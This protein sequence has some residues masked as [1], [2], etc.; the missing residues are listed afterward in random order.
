MRK[1]LSAIIVTIYLFSNVFTITTALNT[2]ERSNPWT[3]DKAT[4]LARITLFNADKNT[5]D[6]LVA[7]GSAS[8]AVNLL[9]P[10]AVGPD[11]VSFNTTITNY[12]ASGFNWWDANHTTRL[13]QLMYAWDPYE[14][15]RKLFSLFEDIFSVNRDTERDITYRDVYDLHSLLF[16]NM[17]GN[18]QVLVKKVLNNNGSPGDYAAGR[19]LDLFNQKD[20]SKPNENFARELLQLFL[21]G[22][23]EPYRSKDDGDIRNYEESDVI[24]LAKILTG[25]KSDSMTHVVSF[26]M[27]NHYSV[28]PLKF[29]SDSIVWTPPPYYNVASG[30][31]DPV[32]IINSVNGN[33]WLTD[34]VIEYI[35]AQKSDQIA[36]FLADR[37]ARFYMSDKPSRTELDQIAQVIKD[38]NF[39]MLPSIKTIL[40]L[41]MIY[42]NTSMNTVRY[43]NP[44]ELTIGSIRFF[45]NNTLSGITIDPNVYDTNLL[46]RLGWTPYFPGSIFGRDGFDN[47]IKWSSTSTQGAWMSASNYFT[48]RNSG[49]GALDFLTMLG[50]QKSEITTGSISVMTHTD[51]SYSGSLTIVS[52]TLNLGDSTPIVSVARMSMA[53]V[54]SFAFD[55]IETPYVYPLDP[56]VSILG[57]ENLDL[58]PDIFEDWMNSDGLFLPENEI[59]NIDS[60]ESIETI[61]PPN[62]ELIV[63]STGTEEKIIDSVLIDTGS[64]VLSEFLIDITGSVLSSESNTTN[65]GVDITGSIVPIVEWVQIIKST[66]DTPTDFTWTTSTWDTNSWI[67][68]ISEPITATWVL[69]GSSDSWVILPVVWVDSGSTDT[70][71]LT[72]K[73]TQSVSTQ[74]VQALAVPLST[75]SISTGTVTLPTFR[76]VTGLGTITIFS[77]TYIWDTR[78]LMIHSGFVISSTSETEILPG[79]S[80]TFDMNSRLIADTIQA[81]QIIDTYEN[82]IYWERRLQS[83]VRL[84]LRNFLTHNSS[85]ATIP[86]APTNTMYFNK[87]IRGLLSILMSQPEY[88]LLSGYDLPTIT[89][90]TDQHF[91][92]GITGKLFF[93]ELYGGNDYMTS[94][95]PKDEYSTYLDYRSNQSGSIAITGT[96]LVDIGDFYMNSALA[97][98]SGGWPGFKSLY[99]GGYLKLFNR[100]W[101]YK[102]SNDHDAAAKQISSYDNTTALSAEWA[103]G[104]LVREE[105]ESSHTISLGSKLPN[106]Y[107]GGHFVNFGWNVILTNPLDQS[108]LYKS[109][110]DTMQNITLTRSYPSNTRNLF[111]D[112]GR[113]SEIAKL[114][115]SQWGPAGASGDMNSVFRFAKVLMNNNIG[116][117]FYMGWFGG[118]DTHGD[119]FNWLNRNLNFVTTAVTNFFNEVKDTQDV[120]IVIF[121]EFGRTN[122]TNW[123]LGTDHGDGGGMYVV[124]SNAA[125]RNKL[126]AGTYGNMSIKNAKYNSLGIGID[127]RSVYGS[128]FNSLYG[129]DESTYF[130]TPISLMNDVSTVQND[131]SLVNYSYRASGQTPLLDIEFTVSGN[132]FD[133]GKAGYTRLLAGTGLINQKITRL[134]EK[135]SPQ[136]YR[137]GIQINPNSQTYFTVESFSN[138]Y[139]LSS[140]SG[141]LTGSTR[142]MIVGNSSRN[143]SQTWSSILPFFSNTM[144]PSLLSG[145]GL[146]LENIGNNILSI[147]NNNQ[148]KIHFA[149]GVTNVTALTY[150]SGST[151]WRGGFTLGQAIDKDLFIPIDA[152][153][154]SDNTSIRIQNITHLFR[155]WADLRWVWMNLNQNVWIEFTWL[156]VGTEYRAISSQDGISWN[157]IESSGS[158]YTSSSTGSIFISTNH[159]SYFTLLSTLNSITPPTCTL[160]ASPTN[161]INGSGTLL[162]WSMMN[163]LTWTLNP[164]NLVLGSSWSLRITPPINV[165]TPYTLVV[166]NSAGTNS[167]SVSVISG[168]EV[169][170]PPVVVPP[171]ITPPIIIPSTPLWPTL[172]GPGWWGWSAITPM[173]DTLMAQGI[174][175]QESIK[176]NRIIDINALVKKI[177]SK[178]RSL[179]L[180]I[181]IL[182]NKLNTRM[183]W[184][185]VSRRDVIIALQRLYM[186]QIELL[187]S[188]T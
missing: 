80:I 139:A 111:R 101:G 48:Y 54:Q 87:Y 151:T 60:L 182:Q 131:I 9:F 134:N 163:S 164:G 175:I 1:I 147:P 77:G 188:G 40:T 138:Q 185:Y 109:H 55:I 51:N 30:T 177:S 27:T 52:G 82:Y 178:W 121:S 174:T 3:R 59:Q 89:T 12:T 58:F 76:V 39:D 170:P 156:P 71:S 172:V 42:S 29:L 153:I 140:F 171:V 130:D 35:F 75:V 96:G 129:F 68:V 79:S 90:N 25:L 2:D 38:N 161:I 105:F 57:G 6:T 150:T 165:T 53:R 78:T 94:I 173:D 84:L 5:I 127:Y 36:L 132:N 43:K 160:T 152:V 159:F 116:R 95:I 114:S 70:G 15:K 166:T 86:V 10:D 113:I 8:A 107:R 66:I 34:N 64:S 154:V 136:W 155:I 61:L 102:H 28:G 126:Q 183:I 22:E 20:P 67:V 4:H 157:D 145:S 137:Y 100:V 123:D 16:A 124:T 187:R 97:Y 115:V 62:S 83:D 18:Y 45:R 33:N 24:A 14:A 13:Y 117:S 125:L 74:I 146:I 32:V 73:N 41:D 108:G 81:D 169:T 92:D 7:A 122:K 180:R 118:Y 168:V 26:D 23:Y 63:D 119:Q 142:P 110:M 21:M 120:T 181:R 133:P 99:D 144:A 162:T 186:D 37:I 50:S 47:S 49:T 112:V 11:R 148:L 44:L 85:G 176:E 167:C 106:I 104:H 65:I 149:S 72:D 141:S 135:I 46:R 19:F 88:V 56:V 98:G 91:L 17:L 69:S 158:L 143:I 31:I 93:V 179:T 103:F 184:D 128:I